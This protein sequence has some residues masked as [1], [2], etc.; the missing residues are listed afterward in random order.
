[1]VNALLKSTSG[2]IRDGLFAQEDLGVPTAEIRD[3]TTAAIS[4]LTS[5][6][7]SKVQ[8]PLSAREWR[9]WSNPEF[10]LRPFGL[11]LEEL[12]TDK[13]E[14]I[15]AILKATFSPEGYE[16]A[17]AAMRINHFLGGAWNILL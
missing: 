10:L 11:R 16:K 12:S 1:M 8:Y 13:A 3:A 6:E 17:L 4:K 5:E 2:N 9:C 7:K 15:L 14:S